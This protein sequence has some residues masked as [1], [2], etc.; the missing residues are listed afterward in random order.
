METAKSYPCHQTPSQTYTAKKQDVVQVLDESDGV[1]EFE[2]EVRRKK[3]QQ[4]AR[5]SPQDFGE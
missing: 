5:N 1:D 2:A 4:Q 3:S